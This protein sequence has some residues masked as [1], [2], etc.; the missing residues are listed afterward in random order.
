ML[1]LGALCVLS[2]GS[3]NLPSW[4]LVAIIFGAGL[5]GGCQ[6]GI[7]T[8]C[9]LVYPA[10]IRSTGVGWALGVGRVGSIAGP[11]LGGLLLAFGFRARSI[12]IAAFIPALGVTVL[13]LTLGRLRHRQHHSA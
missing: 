13:M 4:L 5:G 11:L 12:F 10:A 3:F 9:G 7:N 2:I 8:L 1:A 6:G